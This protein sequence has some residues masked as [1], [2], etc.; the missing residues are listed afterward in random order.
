MKGIPFEK[1]DATGNDFVIVDLS[2]SPVGQEQFTVELVIAICDRNS[3]VG[4]DGVVLLQTHSDSKAPTSVAIRNSDGSPAGMCGNALRCVAKIL[5]RTAGPS[6]Q[7]VAIGDRVV[8]TR[9]TDLEVG[10]VDMGEVEAQPGNPPLANL[11]TLDAV[12]GYSGH[13]LSFGNP[14]YVICCDE[15]PAN[16]AELGARAQ[17]VASQLLGVG[18]VNCGFLQTQTQADGSRLLRVYERGAG[19]TKS[20]GSGACAASAVLAALE[21]I[22]PPHCFELPGGKLEIRGHSP[23]FELLGAA[24]MEFSGVWQVS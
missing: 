15:I 16:W 3:G 6:S 5:A 17:P 21:G 4:A 22:Q 1:W 8:R 24:E 9:I 14:H 11:P 23:T 2:N 12:L 19:V 7:E 18:G 13:L 20:C 10:C